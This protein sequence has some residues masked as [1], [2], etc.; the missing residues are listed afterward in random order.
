MTKEENEKLDSSVIDSFASN[1]LPGCLS[2]VSE[3]PDA[4]YK[5]CDLIV[6]ISGRNGKPWR[7]KVLGEILQK[8][9]WSF[10]CVKV[11]TAG[12]AVL[13]LFTI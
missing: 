12:G 9:M 4:V 10:F 13:S 6:A 11:C 1:M 2:V 5:A 3:I 8:V 7:D